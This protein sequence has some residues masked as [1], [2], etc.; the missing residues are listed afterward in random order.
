MQCKSCGTELPKKAKICPKCGALN[1]KPTGNTRYLAIIGMVIMLLGGLL[2]F[3]QSNEELMDG[4]TPKAYSFG[5][6]NISVIFMWY[7][8]ML[9][10]VAGILLVVAKKEKL[11][12]VTSVLATVVAFV[13]MFAFQFSSTDGKTKTGALN[14]VYHNISDLL[15]NGYGGNTY[16]IGSGVYV[17]ILG[18]IVAIIGVFWDVVKLFKKDLGVDSKYLS[19]SLNQSI[20]QKMFYYRGFYIMFLPVFIMILLFFYWPMLGCRYAFTSY[21]LANPYYIGIFHFQTMLRFD[22]YFWQ[23]FRNTLVLSIVKLILNTGAAVIISLLLNEIT[24][25]AFK[26]SVQTIIYLPHFMSWVVVAAVFK[27]ILSVNSS[28]VVNSALINMGLI[29]NPIDFLGSSKYWTGTF[30]MMNVWKDT[31]WGTILFLATL[32]GISPDLYEAAQIDGANRFKRLIYITLP[33]LANTI[34]TVFILNLA[35][36]MNLFES[37][38]V[39]QSA[40]TYDVSQVLQ[41]YVYNKTFSA[42]FSDYGYT[43]AVGLFKSFVGMILVLGCNYASKKVRGRGIV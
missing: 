2:P 14:Y 36:V 42:S 21:V 5:F 16:S 18:L 7:L 43:T 9:I 39:T 22:T 13:S 23:A 38:F 34:I 24:N 35:K 29:D 40:G 37:V 25:M 26:K 3:V 41:T 12:I 10:I 4:Y 31:G 15:S 11:S 6:M 1:G 19:N 27:M 33:A 17:I 20:T 32:S 30:F 8:F 28:G